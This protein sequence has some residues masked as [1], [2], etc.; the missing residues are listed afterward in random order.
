MIAATIDNMAKAANF[1]AL[2]RCPTCRE[3]EKMTEQLPGTACHFLHFTGDRK[4]YR[5][6]GRQFDRL[7]KEVS[8]C[9]IDLSA[10]ARVR[11]HPQDWHPSPRLPPD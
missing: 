1:K 7:L 4:K 10:S 2:Y 5:K 11:R 8:P 3:K 9:S 6:A